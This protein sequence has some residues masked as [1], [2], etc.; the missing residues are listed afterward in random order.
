MGPAAFVIAILGCGEGEAP[1]QQVRIAEA[2]YES[3]AA[4]TAATEAQLMRQTD[5]AFPVV[6][7]ECRPAGA[8][9]SRVMPADVA[10]P[11]APPS[12]LFQPAAA[13]RNS[14]S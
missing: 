4:C 6:V 11:V 12:R 2:R 1:C 10:L 8:P 13:Q 9:A 7:A 3:Q 5:L 14:R